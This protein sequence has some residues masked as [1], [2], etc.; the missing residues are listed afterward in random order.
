M[1]DAPLIKL[2]G[3]GKNY[4]NIIALRDVDLEASDTA[5]SPA[6]SATTG[7][8]SRRSS[9]WSLLHRHDTGTYEVQGEEVA[10]DSPARRSTGASRPS[11]RTSRSSR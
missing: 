11:T 5:R 6:C 10:F 8:A 3:V 9:R 4:G 7:R 1:T 2:T